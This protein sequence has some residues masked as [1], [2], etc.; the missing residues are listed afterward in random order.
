MSFTIQ[1]ILPYC[2][3]ALSQTDIALGEKIHEGKVRDTYIIKGKRVLVTTDRQSAFDLIL[4][5][6]PFKGQ[7]L[8]RIA[9][10]WFDK[11][12]H[13]IKNHCIAMPDVNCLVAETLEIFPVEFIVR[14]YMTGTTD[15]SIWVNYQNGVRNFCGNTL[16]ENL[17]KSEKLPQII[18]TPTT[19]PEHI[20][21]H[22]ESISREKIIEK[23][24]MTA[25]DFDF[26]AQK[27]LEL[28]IFGQKHCEKNGLILVDTKYEFGKNSEGKIILADEIHT[29]DSSRFWEMEGYEESF[30]KGTDPK[31]FDKDILRR[32]YSKRCDPYA[33][34]KLPEAPQELI[35]EMSYV[36]QT[37]YEKITD[38]EFIPETSTPV[39]E[40]MNRNLSEYFDV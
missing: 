21:S 5:S 18:V 28:F 13:I 12:Q 7:V 2:N 32:W 27:S 3:T 31:S 29:P 15:T 11:T 19:K 20:G 40:R 26:V 38:E 37:A 39:N 16:P 23:G 9:K 30:K 1:K 25:E 33:D 10:F 34:K 6:V 35:S 22:D 36:Y 17:K 8:N 14:A 24:L 4:A